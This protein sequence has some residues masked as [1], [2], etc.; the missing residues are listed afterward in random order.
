[1]AS[2]ALIFAVTGFAV[3]LLYF[4][5]AVLIMSLIGGVGGYLG[6]VVQTRMIESST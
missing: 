4:A 5:E 3:N 1:M 2:Y 6:A